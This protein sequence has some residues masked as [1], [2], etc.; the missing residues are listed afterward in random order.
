PD[1]EV[2]FADVESIVLSRCSMCHA[3]EPL[4]PGMTMPPKGVILDHPELIRLQAREIY[5]Q[6]AATDAMPPA[7]ITE[8]GPEER[9]ML[10]AWYEAGAP[11]E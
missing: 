9:G 6:S 4:W 7:N 3:A 1:E 11:A 5:L 8:L 2:A 10:A